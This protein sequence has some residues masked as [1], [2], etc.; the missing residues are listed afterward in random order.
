MAQQQL[1]AVPD[2]NELVGYIKYLKELQ[3]VP[4]ISQRL[5]YN[6]LMNFF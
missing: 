2:D 3:T 1:S 5:T 4:N 6:E